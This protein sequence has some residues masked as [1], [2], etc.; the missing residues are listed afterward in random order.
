M[1]EIETSSVGKITA[2]FTHEFMNVL[3]TIQET[4]GLM[5]DLIY[6]S[7]PKD[8]QHREKFIR[9][10]A[11]IK[12]QVRRGMEM[13]DRLNTFSHSMEVS[14]ARIDL[15]EFLDQ[16]VLLAGRFAR[17]KHVSLT[18]KHTEPPL[19]ITTD[20]FRLQLILIA[21]LEYLLSSA[22]AEEAITLQ[23]QDTGQG[24]SIQILMETKSGPIVTLGALPD[25]LSHFFEILQNLRAGLYRIASGG[26]VGLELTLP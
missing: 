7:L 22:D 13:S 21:C 5:E 8:F 20:P 24:I 15:N 9:S 26:Q 25:E 18:V 14:E 23:V 16:S 4:S 19:A 10:C 17:L 1:G 2:S 6:M 3:A 11:I 12:E